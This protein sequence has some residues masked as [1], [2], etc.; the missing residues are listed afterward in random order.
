MYP[1]PAPETT[2]RA[3]TLT[4]SITLNMKAP[5]GQEILQ[6]LISQAD[7]LVEN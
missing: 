6:E 2:R 5:K 7:V 3:R 4:I 1:V